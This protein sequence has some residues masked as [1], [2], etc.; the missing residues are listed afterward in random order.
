MATKEK[1]GTVDAAAR[2]PAEAKPEASFEPYVEDVEYLL[3]SVAF[4]VKK[5]GREILS[6]FEITPPQF[7]ALLVLIRHGN[8]TMG[9]LC[10]QL[11]LASSTVTDLTDRMEKNELV[12]RERDP[13][14][15]RVIRLK[16]KEKGHQLIDTVM[17]AR[18]EYLAAILHDLD[19]TERDH[20]I[21]ALEHIHQ[22]MTEEKVRC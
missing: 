22:L 21:R 11:Y 16:V 5:R 6:N 14:D 8:L 1:A 12:A 3:R 2:A 20:L 4:I 10:G 15:R 13:A 18:K 9:E 19:P 7:N 17:K